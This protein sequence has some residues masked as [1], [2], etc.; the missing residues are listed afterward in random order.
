MIDIDYVIW[1]FDGVV[2][3]NVVDGHFIWI[4]NFKVDIGHSPE[5][6]AQCVFNHEFEQVL[7]GEK[8]IIDQLREWAAH[9][10]LS[11]SIKEIYNY[12]LKSDEHVDDRMLGIMAD[13]KSR[14]VGNAIGTNNDP[15]RAKYI[16]REMGLAAH[17][18]HMFAAG[19]MGLLKP[20][21]AFFDHIAT[22]L[23]VAPD[24]LILIDDLAENVD[25]AA[26]AGWQAHQ[27]TGF[28]YEGLESRLGLA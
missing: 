5:V 3:A 13:V 12:W 19:R 27:F 10:Q 14:G 7:R 21:T 17:I 25:A 20:D 24:R 28:D 8:D 22:E 9:V 1:D 16:E 6:F 23:E 2:N 4:D 11:G 26:Q 18:D 15:R